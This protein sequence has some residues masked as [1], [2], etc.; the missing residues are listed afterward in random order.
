MV[1]QSFTTGST[2]QAPCI[3][4]SWQSWVP[5][6][7]V[8]LQGTCVGGTWHVDHAPLA[9]VCV[10]SPQLSL[11]ALS[12]GGTWQTDQLWLLQTCVPSPHGSRHGW[13]CPSMGQSS[14]GVR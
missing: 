3:L 11:H 13:D 12:T 4:L 6:P 1:E 10:P 2:W 9:Q 7:H 8:L 14:S 5:A